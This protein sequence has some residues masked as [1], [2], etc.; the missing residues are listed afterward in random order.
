MTRI[1][2]LICV[3]T[4]LVQSASAQSQAITTVK[5]NKV[6]DVA[7]K[8]ETKDASSIKEDVKD[9]KDAIELKAI[10]VSLN[11]KNILEGFVFQKLNDQQKPVVAKVT[12][13]KDGKTVGSTLTDEEGKFTFD[14]I[15][16]GVYTLVGVGS[17]FMGD[18]TISVTGF[19]E[20]YVSQM[21]LEVAPMAAPAMMVDSYGEM[22]MQ[23]FSTG[24]APTGYDYSGGGG[25][26]G[27]GFAPA[28]GG[29]RR[30]L[31]LTGLVGLVG[32]AGNDPASP[33]N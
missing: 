28:G 24:F 18:E 19:G 26:G 27:G 2:A 29:L 5:I 30:L 17:G 25:Y 14:A 3:A 20:S 33:D 9:V 4:L 23:A 21:P 10:K 11:E 32:L 1:C 6:K 22:P 31:P 8:V 7:S 13:A 12:L 15:K 16:P